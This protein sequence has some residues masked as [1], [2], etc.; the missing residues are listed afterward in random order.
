MLYQSST[1]DRAVQEHYAS[2]AV[3][4]LYKFTLSRGS[5][6]L[7]DTSNYFLL[8]HKA[9]LLA[10]QYCSLVSICNGSEQ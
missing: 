7:Y 4:F 9:D 8:Q 2:V 10:S 3:R 1:T 6:A 5:Y